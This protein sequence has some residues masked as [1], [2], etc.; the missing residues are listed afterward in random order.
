VRV[1]CITPGLTDTEM[2]HVLPDERI[3]AIAA[4][5]PLKRVGQP[6]E[7]ASAIRF[8]L[9]DESSFMTGQTVSVCG[10]RV[11]LP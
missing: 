2:M 4:E 11:M 8:L 10:G 7:I 3:A 9:S 6:E 5:T 1:N